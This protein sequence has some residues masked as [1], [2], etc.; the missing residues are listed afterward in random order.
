[1]VSRGCR[2]QTSH[3]SFSVSGLTLAVSILNDWKD[4]RCADIIG[5]YKSIVEKM[6]NVEILDDQNRELKVRERVLS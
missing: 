6:D 3:T 1:M 5:M 2:G 4:H